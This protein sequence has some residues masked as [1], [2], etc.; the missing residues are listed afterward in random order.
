MEPRDPREYGDVWTWVAKDR[1]TRL[2]IA[3]V[4]GKR[5]QKEAEELVEK[6]KSCLDPA[7]P[8]PVFTSDQMDQYP[9]ALKKAFGRELPDNQPRRGP[10]RKHPRYE[11]SPELRYGQVVKVKQGN[12][13]VS[14]KYTPIFGELDIEEIS[15][16]LVE[17]GNLTIRMTNGRMVRKT[18]G[19]SKA[20]QDHRWAQT[21]NDAFYN[22]IKPN[23]SLRLEKPDGIRKW[24]KRTP[25]MAAGIT[26]HVWTME[27][28]AT[29]RVSPLRRTP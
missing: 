17:R 26:D 2:R 28:L 1:E 7:Y 25:A 8:L 4:C 15:T 21:F 27:E 10:K 6:M 11:P 29:Y 24:L 13:V 5:T 3:S 9:E 18:L 14:I 12:R 23:K 22:F 16:S 19:F 20:F